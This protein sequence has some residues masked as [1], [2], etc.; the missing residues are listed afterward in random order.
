MSVNGGLYR[1]WR[2]AIGTIGDVDEYQEDE[3]RSW[4][5]S[6]VM[7]IEDWRFALVAIIEGDH[8]LLQ[9]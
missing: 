8:L 2:L 3:Y 9:P 5:V 1:I 4:L 7:S 6:K